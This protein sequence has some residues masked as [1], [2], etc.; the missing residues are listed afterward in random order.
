MSIPAKPSFC[1]HCHSEKV[2]RK[3]TR[4]NQ[5]RVIPLYLCKACSKYFSSV[6]IA[7]VKYPPHIILKAL[8]LYNLGHPQTEVV[9]ILTARYK[10]RVPQRTISSWLTRYAKLCAFRQ[11]RSKALKLYRPTDMIK[12]Q[13]L[14]HRQIYVHTFHRAKAKLLSNT[15]NS[16]GDY[17]RLIAYLHDIPNNTFP[18]H[19]FTHNKAGM[20]SEAINRSSQLNLEL[21]PLVQTR[22]QNLANDLALFGLILAKKTTDRHPSIQDFMLTNDKSTL[23]CEVPVYL[24]PENIAHFRRQ[25]FELPL[26]PIDSPITGHIDILQ[27]RQGLIHILDYK[28][29]ARKIQPISQLTIYALALSSLT[30][31]PLKLFKCAWFDEKDYFEFYPLH[32]VYPKQ[33]TFKRRVLK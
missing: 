22:K 33:N 19:L 5:F 7:R 13:R 2:I 24:T 16:R 25:R 12:S 10:V 6:D 9:G 20:G 4:K 29:D 3:G 14:D 8:S 11:L 23:A 28:P 30:G 15:L 17:D 26:E 27:V 31:L 18:H 32:G 21:L 1:P